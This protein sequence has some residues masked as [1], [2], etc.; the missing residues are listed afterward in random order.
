MLR[1]KSIPIITLVFASLFLSTGSSLGRLSNADPILLV[2]GRM[3]FSAFLCMNLFPKAIKETQKGSRSTFFWI[4]F[5]CLSFTISLYLWYF[6]FHHT[7]H[8][9]AL[10]LGNLSPII[11]VFFAWI[12]LNE[13]LPWMAW[14]SLMIAIMG[15]YLLFGTNFS[16]EKDT[17][18][19][20]CIGIL[21]SF[22]YALYFIGLRKLSGRIETLY[23]MPLIALGSCMISMPI[24]LFSDTLTLPTDL[25][26][27]IC[28]L[29][30]G[31]FVQLIGQGLIAFSFS[32]LPG[33][34]SFIP[35]LLSPTFALIWAYLIFD[36][37]VKYEQVQ[38]G[39]LIFMALGLILIKQPS[40]FQQKKI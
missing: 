2:F 26:S 11:V 6:A 7:T 31:I 19:G 32:R 10:F 22:F 24:L 29:L 4:C 1:S 21:T 8:S 5:T 27:W 23:L 36:E 37:H 9:N 39:L 18:F 40:A 20:D 13:T 3:I 17:I 15:G 38:G 34:F 33:Y 16:V 35:C 25:E 14:P 28:I 12:F 30:I